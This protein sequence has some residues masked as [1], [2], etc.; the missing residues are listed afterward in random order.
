M[1][2]LTFTGLKSLEQTLAKL[3]VEVTIVYFTEQVNCR[4]CRREHEL[5][6]ELAEL[7]HKLHLEVY[8]FTADRSVADK[9]GINKVPGL[10]LVG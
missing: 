1:I 5:L 2:S 3:R 7:S 6:V 9:N 10:V 4:H 8:N